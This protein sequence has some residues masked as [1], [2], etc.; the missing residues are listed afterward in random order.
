MWRMPPPPLRII[1]VAIGSHG[2]V[3]PFL[4]LGRIL[5]DRGHEVRLVAPAM[6]ESL[7]RS[8]GLQ[9]VPV[10]TIEQFER[11]SSKADLWHPTRSFQVLAEGVA[12]LLEP[13]YRAVVLNH[14]RGRTMLVLSSLALAGRVAQETLRVPAASVH[15]SP[16]IFRSIE[17]P[18]RNPPLPVADWAPKWWNRLTYAAADLLVI[19]RA[20]A[21][22]LNG[23]RAS[24]GLGPVKRILNQWIH[25]PDGIIGLFP[26]WFAPPR[27]DWPR[28]ASLTG[29]PLFDESD[30]TPMD[31]QLEEF[32]DRG[33]PPIAFTP[34]SAMRHGQQFFA[35][36][37][38]ACRMLGRRGLL[39]SRHVA[40]VPA[41]LPPE[42]RHVKY[43]PFSL[44]LPRCAA[45]VHHGGIG[46]ASQALRAAIP[47][48]VMP[49][50]HDQADN[51]MRLRRLGVAEVVPA[52]RFS[53]R[54]AAAA[55]ERAMDPAHRAVCL[56]VKQRFA[57]E[58]PFVKTAELVEQ[59]F[60]YR[61]PASSILNSPIVPR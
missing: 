54:N 10:G 37:V 60:L 51:A 36:S 53:T 58:N 34:G 26:P 20:L 40:H 3:H 8:L 16:A 17:N 38:K 31:R 19:D 45:I 56:V 12:E 46:T 35:T 30:V 39:V 6:Y 48:L 61:P 33:E 55:L 59:I 15:L 24:V 27:G 14:E 50:A 42:I 28:Q 47:Q 43:C 9:F 4:A 57:G 18:A 5:Q 1:I 21:G 13:V 23:F 32:L 2:D 25:S 29:F 41:H 22:P 7:S 44:L 52:R 49:M 11:I